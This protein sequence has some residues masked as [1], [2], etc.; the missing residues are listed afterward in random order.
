MS[1][2]RSDH[3]WAQ[4]F[5]RLFPES[6]VRV[7]YWVDRPGPS[8]VVFCVRTGSPADPA[9]GVLECNGAFAQARPGEWQWL[10]V[11]AQEM[12]NNIHAPKFGP[13]WVGFL[14]IFNTY[15]EDIGLKVARFQVTRSGG[16]VLPP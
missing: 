15:K 3:Q 5:F 4:G 1:Q 7:R 16:A 10:E 11:K 14:L 2:I 13:P 9:T 6:V 12:L 8:Q